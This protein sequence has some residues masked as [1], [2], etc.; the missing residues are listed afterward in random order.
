MRCGKR[1]SLLLS[2]FFLV[3]LSLWAF[4]G[5]DAKTEPEEPAVMEAPS[6]DMTKEPMQEAESQR[7]PSGTESGKASE[8][9][10]SLP[11]AE[12]GSLEKAKKIAEDGGLIVGSRRDELQA[13]IDDLAS[14][15]AVAE[16]VSK[17]K[18][19]EIASLKEDLAEA[20]EA[21]GT[22]PYVML[23]GI[24]GF[25]D[26]VPS[27]GV[28]ITLGTRIGNHIMVELGAD[29]TIGRFT[30]PMTIKTFSIDNFEFRA[31]VGWMF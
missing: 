14:D 1:L 16:E 2:V 7:M 22:K 5:R 12:V 13:V 9:Q 29:Y 21:V 28:G 18:D 19:D 17:A 10:M 15:I 11:P 24:I 20:E 4:P 31:S 26:V 8:E 6:T 25:E 30:A 3:S 23:D 27:Y